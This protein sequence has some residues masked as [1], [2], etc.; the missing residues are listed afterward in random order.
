MAL[1]TSFHGPFF[2][3]AGQRGGRKLPQQGNLFGEAA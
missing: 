1:V 3:G 2:G